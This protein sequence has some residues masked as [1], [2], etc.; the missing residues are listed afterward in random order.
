[1]TDTI[2]R[3]VDEIGRKWC[4][5]ALIALRYG[6]TQDWVRKECQRGNLVAKKFGNAWMIDADSAR[7]RWGGEEEGGE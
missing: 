6:Y 4:T 1:M 3:G 2:S 5:V 7:K